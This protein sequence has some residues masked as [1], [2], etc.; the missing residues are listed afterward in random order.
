VEINERERWDM[1]RREAFREA[2]YADCSED[3]VALCTLLLAPEPNAATFTPLELSE[4]RYGRVPRVY[5]ELLADRAVSPALQRRMYE[6][7]PCRQVLPIE[8][9]HSAYFSKP[10]ELVE[11]ILVAGGDRRVV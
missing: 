1:L 7:F 8:A 5:I 9:S 10:D 2:L 4:E 3:D 6:S 11:K